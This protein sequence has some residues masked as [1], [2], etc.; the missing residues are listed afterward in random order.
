VAVTLRR[1]EEHEKRLLRDMLD[2]Y[3]VE[4]AALHEPDPDF[5]PL[6]FPNFDKYWLEDHRSPW[7]IVHEET[8]AGFALVGRYSWSKLPVDQ[9]LIE[10]YVEPEFRRRGV[11]LAAARDLFSRFPGQWE[12]QV[13]KANPG[14]LEFWRRTIGEGGYAGWQVIDRDESV[15]HRFVVR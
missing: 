10:Y 2:D 11:G 4:D 9:G 1:V 12:L 7:W 8:L 5:D 14:G 15:L 3:L 6:E 13:S